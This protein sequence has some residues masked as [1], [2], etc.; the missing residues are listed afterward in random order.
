[1]WKFTNKFGAEKLQNAGY[2]PIENIIEDKILAADTA[3]ITFD[4]IPQGYAHLHIDAKTTWTVAGD[5][6]MGCRVNG[7]AGATNHVTQMLN[8]HAGTPM[9]GG[10]S[11]NMWFP[12]RKWFRA[13]WTMDIPDYSRNTLKMF[14]S[15]YYTTYADNG[16]ASADGEFTGVCGGFVIGS[17]G[18]I[19]KLEFLR[20]G[21]VF[22]AGSRITLY[23]RSV[24]PLPSPGSILPV[25][26]GTS[27]PASPLTGQEAILVDSLTAP[28]YQ[29]RFRYNGDSTS[30]YKWEFVGGAPAYSELQVGENT[31]STSFTDLA[32]QGP[33]V[34][35]PRNG[36]YIV[37]YG[38][39]VTGISG[40]STAAI[41]SL[42]DSSSGLITN[43]GVNASPPANIYQSVNRI[44]RLLNLTAGRTIRQV[45]SVAFG[46]GTAQ[47][48][49][50]IIKITPIR[51]A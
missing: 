15:K 22:A 13:A 37:E 32:T 16:P 10:Y 48:S 20:T 17:V 2:L 41:V 42:W 12:I 47:F 7:D 40:T 23:G 49:Q 35:V 31:A 30:A 18:P 36:D 46:G 1:M 21:R 14:T 11:D 26:Y 28:T 51:V 34:P 38:A 3:V 9:P 19:T 43:T 29:W 39:N 24:V 44:A 6:L 25:T 4:N 50:R 8:A 27:L 33:A 5:D 45:Y